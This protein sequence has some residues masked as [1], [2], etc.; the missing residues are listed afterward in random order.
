MN[1]KLY[2]ASPLVMLLFC[3]GCG[4]LPLLVGGCLGCAI[5]RHHSGAYEHFQ[6]VPPGAAHDTERA[7]MAS[8]GPDAEGKFELSVL[9]VVRLIE[10]SK[11]FGWE[12]T[13]PNEYICVMVLGVLGGVYAIVQIVI[14]AVGLGRKAVVKVRGG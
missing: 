9:G 6:D 10:S 8:A 3:A 2:A 4:F 7:A 13:C 12:L 14:R 11:V 1:R 5:I